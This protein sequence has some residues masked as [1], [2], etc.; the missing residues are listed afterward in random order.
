MKD[1]YQKNFKEYHQQTFHVDPS[2]FLSPLEK[3]LNP[4]AVVLD[5][6]RERGTTLNI[7]ITQ[8]LS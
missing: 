1:Y 6:A 5:I 4:E 7:Q 8:V 2:S 3:R